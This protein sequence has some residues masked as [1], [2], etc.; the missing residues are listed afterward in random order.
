MFDTHGH[1]LSEPHGE[2]ERFRVTEF[3]HLVDETEQFLQ[4]I[5]RPWHQKH[6]SGVPLFY[7]GVSMGA[8]VVRITLMHVC[9]YTTITCV[10]L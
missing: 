9:I 2:D 10:Q 6:C 7:G 8:L 4:E 1:G 5:V 3:E